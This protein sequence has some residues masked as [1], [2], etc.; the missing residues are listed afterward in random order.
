MKEK[1]ISLLKLLIVP[2][3]LLAAYLVVWVIW[4]S[5]GLPTDERLAQITQGWFNKYGIIV[6][7][8]SGM[9]EG[10]LLLGQYYPGGLVVFLG[11]ISAGHNIPKVIGVVSIVSLAFLIGYTIDYLMGKYGWYKLF[12]KF[13]LNN[14][15]ETSKIKLQKQQFNAIFLS[16]WEPNPAS[17]T[18]TAAGISQLPFKKFTLYS[19]LGILFWNTFWGTRIIWKTWF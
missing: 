2:I 1:I 8:I 9:I 16:Y 10:I 6:V 4:R 19:F 5:F 17:V 15:L 12:L 3:S 13:A 14:S 11:V 7:F 18:A